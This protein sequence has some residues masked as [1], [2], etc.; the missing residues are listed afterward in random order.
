MT[1]ITVYALVWLLFGLLHSWLAGTDAKRILEPVMRQHYR[2][3]YNLFALAHTVVVLMIGRWLFAG[4]P[5]YDLPLGVELFR[6]ILLFGGV[7]VL[8][9]SLGQYDLGLFSGLKQLN[10]QRS[11]GHAAQLQEQLQTGGIHRFVRHPLYSALF[12][13]LWGVSDTPF[14]LATAVFASI[15]LLFGTYSEEKKLIALYG[16]SYQEY[17]EDVSAFVP[18]KAVLKLTARL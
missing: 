7:A 12:L 2:L 18:W 3:V 16:Q 8:L 10:E 9:A 14:G 5:A 13:L 15:Y 4:Y 1:A 11:V 6:W 17:R